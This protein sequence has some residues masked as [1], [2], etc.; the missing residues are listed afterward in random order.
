MLG[1]RMVGVDDVQ[2]DGGGGQQP[3]DLGHRRDQPRSLCGVE[4]LEEGTGELVAAGVEH[5]AR[6]PALGGEPRDPHAPVLGLRLHRQQ[7]LGL[8]GAQQPAGVAGI[9]PETLPQASHVLAPLADLP[10]QPGLADPP[11]AAQVVI[12]QHARALGDRAV[13]PPYLFDLRR[14]HSLTLVR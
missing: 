14:I 13:E 12:V 6:R 7:A 10:E 3:L 4:R 5:G 9:E 2:R 1:L 11:A 8:Q